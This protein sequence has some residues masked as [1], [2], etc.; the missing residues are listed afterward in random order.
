[1]AKRKKKAE[2]IKDV[3][4]FDEVVEEAIEEVV[5][6]AMDCEDECVAECPKEEVV[7]TG[8][9]KV[10]VTANVK[11]KWVSYK[12]FDQ[13]DMPAEDAKAAKWCTVL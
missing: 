11:Y 9:V 6:E 5:E 13:L 3:E 1:M 10:L 8:M 12:R 2:A 4:L 7:D